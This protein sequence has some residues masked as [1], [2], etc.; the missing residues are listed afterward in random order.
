M[1][2]ALGIIV[3]LIIIVIIIFKWWK[4][5]K[6]RELL[7]TVT[8]LD[9]GTRSERM[10]VLAL[11]KHGISPLAIFHDVYIEKLNGHFSQVDVVVCTKV[12]VIV[13]EDKHFGGWIFGNGSSTNWTQV[14]AFGNEKYKFYNPIKQNEKHI[15]QLKKLL[16][17]NV[18]FFSVIVFSGNSELKDISGV[19]NDTYIIKSHQL[20][21]LVQNILNTNEQ[22][23]YA[24]NSLV[25]TKLKQSVDNGRNLDIRTKHIQNIRER[26]I[27]D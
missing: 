27:A 17:E 24:N 3:A 9:S 23:K 8:T 19:P 26:Q 4:D 6:D 25:A 14:M 20:L 13:I 11:L 15:A 16:N 22:I 21:S 10:I 12:G 5:K 1:E 18:L 7:Q 2:I